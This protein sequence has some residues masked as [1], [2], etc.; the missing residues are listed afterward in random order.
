MGKLSKLRETSV[1]KTLRFNL[2]YFGRGGGASP[3]A[4]V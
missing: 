3:G 4:C 1:F 2:H